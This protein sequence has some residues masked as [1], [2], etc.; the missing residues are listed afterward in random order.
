VPTAP[1][2]KL[3][4]EARQV[5]NDVVPRGERL[6]LRVALTRKAWPTVFAET[7]RL[8]WHAVTDDSLLSTF[9]AMA[10]AS[11]Q[12]RRR[13]SPR[14]RLATLRTLVNVY[15][16]SDS[17]LLAERLKREARTLERRLKRLTVRSLINKTDRAKVIG[18]IREMIAAGE[19][20]LDEILPAPAETI[21]TDRDCAAGSSTAAGSREER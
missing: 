4:N 3:T 1:P 13:G 16:Y 6:K 8:S 12:P 18:E 5:I 11:L 7:V 20:S 14:D 19:I 15:V 17:L 21:E 2:L 9:I 10:M